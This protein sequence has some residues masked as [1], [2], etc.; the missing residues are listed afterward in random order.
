MWTGSLK[1][2]CVSDMHEMRVSFSM[3]KD[4]PGDG[5]DVGEVPIERGAEGR[6]DKPIGVPEIS[7]GGP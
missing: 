5:L 2:C 7:V 3:A 4:S 6:D 1:H